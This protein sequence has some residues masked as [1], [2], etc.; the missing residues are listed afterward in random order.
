[1][2]RGWLLGVLLSIAGCGRLEFERLEGAEGEGGE[3]KILYPYPSTYHALLDTTQLKLQPEYVGVKK[4]SVSPALPTG[5]SLDETTGKISG[6]PSTVADRVKYTI[7]GTG[8]AGEAT[9]EIYLTALT[10]WKVD[11][12]SDIPDDDGG[13]DAVCFSTGAG[14]CTLRAAVECAN[15]HTTKKLIL[16][17]AGLIAVNATLTPLANDMVIA[18]EG[19]DTTVLSPNPLGQT[20]ALL[21]FESSYQIRLENL[22]VRNFTPATGSTVMV[23]DGVFEAFEVE[24]RGNQSASSGA[25]AGIDRGARAHFENVTFLENEAL[26]NP[27]WGGV[28]IGAG[29]ETKIAVHS[30]TAMNNKAIWGSFAYVQSGATLEL[31]NSSLVGNQAITAGTLASPDGHY[32]VIHS[33]LAFNTIMGSQSAGLYF[34]EKDATFTVGN[35]IIAHNK[36]GSGIVKNCDRREEM[37]ALTSLGGNVLSDDAGNCAAFFTATGDVI[38]VDPLLE[39]LLPVSAGGHTKTMPLQSESK[40]IDRGVGALCPPR[41]QRGAVRKL[42]DTGTCDSGAYE[43]E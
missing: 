38:A 31:V 29:T 18:G 26:G 39:S 7:T 20:Q 36:N 15:K 12:R 5:L 22:S 25:V 19:I 34:N 9:A 11:A 43:R 16:L 14:G 37:G 8:A 27:G 32:R 28:I 24:F 10:G 23:K 3:I 4:F 30:S 21:S 41:D 40:A 2:K 42:S 17:P 6:V 13:Q 33:T 1:M 35:S